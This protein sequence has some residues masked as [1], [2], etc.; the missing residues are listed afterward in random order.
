[1]NH[2]IAAFTVL[3]T[4]TRCTANHLGI[5]MHWRS[6][7]TWPHGETV[8]KLSGSTL[9][10]QV[11]LKR[12]MSQLSSPLFLFLLLYSIYFTNSINS[13]SCVCMKGYLTNTNG[14]RLKIFLQIALSHTLYAHGRGFVLRSRV[15]H[16]LLFMSVPLW[17]CLFV[18]F[19]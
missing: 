6:R 1:M 16:A 2:T 19:I 9:S 18:W 14:R 17:R 15:Q 11:H 7:F 10:L 12:V 13:S 5:V 4:G 8:L 3:V